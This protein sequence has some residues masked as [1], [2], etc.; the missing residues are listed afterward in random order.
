MVAQ[1]VFKETIII[2]EMK[3]KI[4]KSSSRKMFAPAILSVMIC[5]VSVAQTAV[6]K[7]DAPSPKV[8]AEKLDSATADSLFIAEMERRM[9]LQGVEVVAQKPLV[10][11]EVDRISYDVQSDKDNETKTLLDMLKKVPMVSV[12]GQDE[13]MVNGTSNFVIY[14][15]GHPE[16]AMAQNYKYVF[17]AIPAS[18]VKRVEVITEP[19]AKYDAEG[20]GAILNI[21]TD[22]A[23]QAVSTKGASGT[24][25]AGIDNYADVNGNF[26]VSSNLGKVATSVNYGYH[27]LNRHGMRQQ[28]NSQMRYVD[29]GNESESSSALDDLSIDVHY[30]NIAASYNFDKDNL[31]SMSFGGFFTDYSALANTRSSLSNSA[32]EPIYSY[33]AHFDT[34]YTKYYNFNG[35]ADYEHR[36]SRQG[37]TLT[38]SYMLSTTRNKKT[39]KYD[40]FDTQSMPFPYEGYNLRS[41]E[42]FLEHT[43]QIDWTR[44]F[45]GAFKFEMG[46]KYINRRNKSNTSM[47]YDGY[48]EGNFDSRF[49]HLTQVAAAYTSLSFQ[50]DKLSARAGLRYEHSF[51]KAKY[52]DGSQTDYD[53]R[54]NDWVPSANVNYQISPVNSLKLAFA[55][56]I[57]RPGIEYLNPAVVATPTT[58]SYGN[59]HLGSSR[60]YSISATF[61]HISPKLVYNVVPSYT[62]SDDEIGE[63]HMVDNNR[64]VTTYGNVVSSRSVAVNAF[65]QWMITQKTSLMLNGRYGMNHFKSDAL[66]I[67]LRRWD[68]LFFYAQLSQD[69]PLKIKATANVGEFGGGAQSLYARQ[70]HVWFH[71]IGLQRSFLKDDRL[72]VKIDAQNPF[73]HRMSS[74]KSYTV[75]GDYVGCNGFKYS[76]RKFQLSVTWRFGSTTVDVKKAATT[77]ENDDVVGG[78]K[79]ASTSGNPAQ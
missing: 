28:T 78:S 40:Y 47:I 58:V 12:N 1:N 4:R 60:N 37:E 19:G 24:V 79:A 68:G 16:P 72:T 30:G 48:E 38:L 52:P 69:L 26:Y 20:V 51:L 44:P 65:V 67:D 49:E 25:G 76:M 21:V 74:F 23:S 3:L 8:E 10:K 54:L 53:R 62:F 31:L 56:R 63:V 22:D 32:G 6:T 64:M 27:H 55:T 9:E 33:N 45:A 18:A 29:S 14:H 15:N 7:T 42:N 13:I 61:M 77:I 57:N 34:P 46:G 39:E 75:K 71:G 2:E 17:K 41:K 36:T 5:S 43:A 70:G 35:R 11:N 66:G 73:S 50:K 59:S